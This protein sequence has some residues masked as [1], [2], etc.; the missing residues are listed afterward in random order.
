MCKLTIVNQAREV[1][2]E[3]VA[4]ET[5]MSFKKAHGKGSAVVVELHCGEEI[6]VDTMSTLRRLPSDAVYKA[7]LLRCVTKAPE[8]LDSTGHDVWMEI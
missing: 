5:F 4:P 1:I 3:G 8:I 7:R 2:A 6:F